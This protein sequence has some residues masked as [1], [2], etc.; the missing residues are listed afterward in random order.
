MGVESEAQDGEVTLL[1]DAEYEATIGEEGEEV[2]EPDPGSG[3][4]NPEPEAGETATEVDEGEAAEESEGGSETATEVAEGGEGEGS[5]QEDSSE[6]QQT[7]QQETPE[8]AKEPFA[9]QYHPNARDLETINGEIQQLDKQFE[10]GELDMADYREKVRPLEREAAK[11]EMGQEF[12][13]QSTQQAWEQVQEAFFGA[14]PQYAQDPALYGALDATLRELY[15][16]EQYANYS[17][18]QFLVE[19]KN[20]VDGRFG[21]GNAQPQAETSGEG[22]GGKQPTQTGETPGEGQ[23]QNQGEQAQPSAA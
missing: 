19:A 12:S 3:D 1:T 13:A 22:D 20:R 17:M 4:G 15:A 2:P 14:N 18:A 16:D 7:Q 8:W 6:P 9:P 10:E 5:G 21:T 11:A 23:G